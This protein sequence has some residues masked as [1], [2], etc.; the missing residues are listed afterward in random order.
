MN[1]SIIFLRNDLSDEKTMILV[2]SITK[3]T[4]SI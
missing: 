1:E 3:N 2:E 4:D